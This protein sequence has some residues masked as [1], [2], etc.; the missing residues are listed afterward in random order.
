MYKISKLL[1]QGSFG[2]VFVVFAN[3][4]DEARQKNLRGGGRCRRHVLLRHR[5]GAAYKAR[6]RAGLGR[7]G[8]G[9][10]GRRVSFGF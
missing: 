3:G 2:Q 5:P 8:G 10:A 4:R 1:G 7:R 9:R 6:G